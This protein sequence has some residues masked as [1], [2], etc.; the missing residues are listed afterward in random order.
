M[1]TLAL[2]EPQ[3]A[4]DRLGAVTGKFQQKEE[5]GLE[6][7]LLAAGVVLGGVLLGAAVY[8]LWRRRARYVAERD[9]ARAAVVG[10]PPPPETPPS[11]VALV[12]T[13]EA[14]AMD[15]NIARW[16]AEE[17]AREAAHAASLACPLESVAAGSAAFVQLGA[18]SH[19]RAPGTVVAVDRRGVTVVS[20]ASLP[21]EAFG[22]DAVL[23][24]FDVHGGATAHPVRPA[25]ERT[26]GQGAVRLSASGPGA[27]FPPG[28]RRPCDVAGQASA[29]GSPDF[30]LRLVELG[31]D[32]ATGDGAPPAPRGVVFEF[33]TDF[34]DGE[35]AEPLA[36]T[37]GA[38]LAGPNGA[39]RFA[40][41]FTGLSLGT[42]ARLV[43]RLFRAAVA[44]ASGVRT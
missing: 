21:A 5:A 9:A 23:V 31:V 11:E 12:T 7:V 13:S 8:A 3:K 41:T 35:E 30:P 37:V 25:A 2:V 1:N 17:A 44:D 36:C 19:V 14:D 4:R 40:L 20:E 33:W 42:R 24:A 18:P 27:A 22:P 29:A 6:P 38:E 39:P 32:G 16:A 34:D 26:F 43:E 10:A 28:T 15:K